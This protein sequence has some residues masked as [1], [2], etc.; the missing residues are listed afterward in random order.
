MIFNEEVLFLHVPKTG[1]MSVTEFLLRRLPTPVTFTAPEASD[2]PGRARFLQG[3]RHETLAEA[4]SLL[5][6]RGV[7]IDDFGL[8]LATMRNPYELEV[9]RYHYLR[10]DN[11][12]DDNESRRL[13]LENE[14]PVYLRQAGFFGSA[15][16]RFERYYQLAGRVPA[17]LRI[18]R[19]ESLES[20]LCRHIAPFVSDR[21]RENYLEVENAT[22]HSPYW[23]HYD[24]EAEELCY[25]RHRWLFDSGYFARRDDFRSSGGAHRA[26][27]PF[28]KVAVPQ[29]IRTI[30]RRWDP[31]PAVFSR[32][33]EERLAV[34]DLADQRV[35]CV[36]GTLDLT[37]GVVSGDL[38]VGHLCSVEEDQDVV[39]FYEDRFDRA[40]LSFARCDLAA[41]ESLVGALDEQTPQF[42]LLVIRRA[43]DQTLRPALENLLTQL[44]SVAADDAALVMSVPVAQRTGLKSFINNL[45]DQGLE[46]GP[47]DYLEQEWALGVMPFFGIENLRSLLAEHRWRLGEL[48]EPAGLY[49][50]HFVATRIKD[51]MTPELK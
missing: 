7:D 46:C 48:H 23:E 20:D 33:L 36:E 15:P 45:L 17:N 39:D 32:Y 40:D 35:L 38:Q 30:S 51:E 44:D 2:E 26:S 8:I 19:F 24:A 49:A 43:F 25:Q 3:R 21:P 11:E 1:G 9:S 42:D 12:W 28:R 27:R 6:Y 41:G 37:I 29:E 10:L 14:F 5:S 4:A 22:E 16:P 31:D 13:A 18:L 34:G 50:H 47:D